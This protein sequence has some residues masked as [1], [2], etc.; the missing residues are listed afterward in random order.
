MG[1]LI[2]GL[3][4]S[5]LQVTETDRVL[6]SITSELRKQ[7]SPSA[8]RKS[9]PE[10]DLQRLHQFYEQRGFHPAW[11]DR[12]GSLPRAE[13]LRQTL[14]TADRDG[15][16]VTA[17]HPGLIAPL[18]NART[19]TQLARLDLLLTDAFFRYSVHLRAGRFQES[20]FHWDIAPPEVDPVAELRYLLTVNSF[21][22]ALHD[23]AP[24]HA[25]YRR[26][27]EALKTY[28]QLEDEG[29]WPLILAG[30]VLELGSRHKQVAILRQRLIAEGDLELGPEINAL[31][32]D[33]AVKFAVEHF[34]I[35]H[36]L[37]MDGR[38]GPNTRAAMNVTASERIKQIQFNMERWRWLPKWLGKR[39]I[40]V[41]AAGF[42]LAVVENEDIQF[43]MGV[44][45]GKPDRP[46]P[47]T[48]SKLHTIVINPYW[49]LPPT[50]IFED[51]LPQQQR[52]PTFFTSKQIRVFKNG[53]ELDPVKID[54]KKV[55]R[56]YFPYILRQDPGPQNSLGRIKFLFS[57]TYTV[58]LHDTPGKQL[59]DKDSR[60]FSSGCIRVEEPVQLA[61][62]LLGKEDGWTVEKIQEVIELDEYMKL[63][64]PDSVPI[65]L[66]YMTTWVD[67][68]MGVHFRP[69]IYDRD[70]KWQKCDELPSN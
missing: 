46:T 61:S 33:E 68:N 44:I 63:E 29:G 8:S 36:G 69:D 4:A 10:L 53:E 58:Y 67:E 9:E 3:S 56:D 39:Y 30:P 32:F 54:W 11:V 5:A 38:V 17:Y 41:N 64:I 6:Q 26:L 65:Y 14:Q 12:S 45:I 42:N 49:T 25:G 28:R 57:N 47:V 62:Y 20:D 23:L 2:T 60:A 43:A 27:R 24:S 40:M 37:K 1:L 31:F 70:P 19:P 66:L 50:I 51:F 16:N 52:D 35:R 55:N 18:W 34:Q 59:F 21:Q 13:V 15:L 7:L 48:S 22:S